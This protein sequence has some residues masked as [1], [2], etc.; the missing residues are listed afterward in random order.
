MNEKE[1]KNRV[2]ELIEK[3][4][5][6]KADFIH[7][8]SFYCGGDNKEDIYTVC[9]GNDELVVTRSRN[10]WREPYAYIKK[11]NGKD[12]WRAWPNEVRIPVAVV[13]ELDRIMEE[14][15]K[16]KDDSL[17]RGLARLGKA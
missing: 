11:F 2:N 15:A 17:L 5:F 12:Y 8:H 4:D 6:K 10:M 16:W 14:R 7:M 9:F 1:L 3:V 13:D